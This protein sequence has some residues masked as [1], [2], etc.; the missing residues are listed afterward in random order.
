MSQQPG[1][2]G[3]APPFGSGPAA[4]PASAER[5][6]PAEYRLAPGPARTLVLAAAGLGLVIYLL[7]FVG[8]VSVTS[9][10]GGPMLVGGGLLAGTAALPRAGRVL[11]PAAVLVVTGTL[12]LLQLVT[13]IGGQ[14]VVVVALVLAFL[15]TGAVLG[16]LLLDTGLVAAWASRP[17]LAP[18]FAQQYGGYPPGPAGPAPGYGPP[19]HSQPGHS[20]PGFGSP[21]GYGPYGAGPPPAIEAPPGRAGAYPGAG[22][23]APGTSDIGGSRHGEPSAS[24]PGRAE[25]SPPGPPQAPAADGSADPTTTFPTT[26]FPA[27]DQRGLADPVPHPE[28]ATGRHGAPEPDSHRGPL[29]REPPDASQQT[30]IVTPEDR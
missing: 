17:R 13:G 23:D 24:E 3:P 2:S 16:A 6:G 18:P 30:R 11:A 28:P 27:V 25:P 1:P 19:G 7:G 21:G 14:T 9:S 8:E 29:P 26:T 20:P 12:L 15:E 22:Y 4:E 10:F 5:A